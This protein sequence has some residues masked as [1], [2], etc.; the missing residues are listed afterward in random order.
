MWECRD[1]RRLR[2]QIT[3]GG[4]MSAVFNHVGVTNVG[5]SAASITSG[6]PMWECRDGRSLRVQIT[7]GGEMSAVFNHVGVT[8]SHKYI[9]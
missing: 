7:S 2:V 5:M 9:E 1:G 6:S 4:E 3:S 8:N